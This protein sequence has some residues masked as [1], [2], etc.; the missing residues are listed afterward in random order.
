MPRSGESSKPRAS[1]AP[2]GVMASKKT[3]PAALAA[4]ESSAADAAVINDLLSQPRATCA[5]LRTLAATR[6]LKRL[7]QNSRAK[8]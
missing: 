6:P 8:S 5:G 3:Y 7:L 4:G 1:E 2:R